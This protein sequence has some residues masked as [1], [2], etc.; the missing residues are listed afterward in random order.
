MEFG[1][2]GRQYTRDNRFSV[3]SGILSVVGI[4]PVPVPIPGEIQLLM[5]GFRCYVNEGAHGWSKSGPI[6][7]FRQWQ[8][9][10]YTDEDQKIVWWSVIF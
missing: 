5:Y 10:V 9:D 6:D 8:Y 2:F 7:V 1:K 3:A 4:P